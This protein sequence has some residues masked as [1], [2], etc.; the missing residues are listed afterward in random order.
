MACLRAAD[1]LLP[2]DEIDMKKWAVTACDQF[3]SQPEYW[4]QV[5]EYVKDSDSTLHMIYPEVYLGTDGEEGYKK[6]I[7][8]IQTYMDECLENG[9]LRERVHQGYVLTARETSSG[10]R[11]GLLAALDLEAYNYRKGTDAK[12]RATEAT[13]QERIPARVGIRR[14]AAVELPHVMMLLDD[15][16]CSLLEP[17]YARRKEYEKLYD[18]ELMLDGGRVSGYALEGAAAE[19]VSCALKR[20]ETESGD[21]FLTVGDGNHSLAAAKSFWES[22]K[23]ELSDKEQID[24]PARYALVEIV[25]IHNP[26]L[27]F[28]P[29]HRVCFG[30]DLTSLKPDFEK[31]LDR[32]QIEWQET[33]K[34]ADVT[35]VQ[36]EE[37]VGIKLLS[38]GDH[39]A[40]EFLQDFLDEYPESCSSLEIDYIHDPKAA[41]QM[42]KEENTCAI[43]LGPVNK[44]MLFAAVDAGG[45]L[46]RKTF[47]I[48]TDLEKR[49]YIECRKIK[50]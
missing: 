16:K 43:L 20:L 1:I 6:R 11:V 24:H 2:A 30:M 4:Q 8:N 25:N 5:S 22:L 37:S 9:V 32:R 40:V 13:V 50:R 38:K 42:A 39:L 10:V 34:D 12:V 29:I 41:A 44:G 48:G 21:I 45:V 18:T 31:Y 47:S 35:F 46:P 27:V 26:A 23:E 14:G 17:L 7:R 15:P 36:Q 33:T 49:Y 3:T 19:E 28:H